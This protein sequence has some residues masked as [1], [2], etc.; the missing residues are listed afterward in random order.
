MTYNWDMNETWGSDTR[1]LVP[2]WTVSHLF[3]VSIIYLICI[4]LHPHHYIDS[5]GFYNASFSLYDQSNP[6]SSIRYKQT[7]N[8][9]YIKTWSWK[10]LYYLNQIRWMNWSGKIVFQ[11]HQNQTSETLIPN[12]HIFGTLVSL[13][14]SSW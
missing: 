7:K 14:Y 11:S 2:T 12:M 13:T 5:F 9:T 10:T 8:I 1:K 3:L 4:S 6:P